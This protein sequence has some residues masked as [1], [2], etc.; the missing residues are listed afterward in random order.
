MTVQTAHLH[1][2]AVLGMEEVDGGGSV[3]EMLS[4][5]AHELRAPLSSLSAAAEMIQEGDAAEQQR[6]ACIIRRQA[7]RLNAII[8][9][10]LEAYGAASRQQRAE[11]GAV[12]LT[13]LLEEACEEQRLQF[14]GHRFELRTERDD[15][16]IVDRRM[17]SIVVSNLLS[18][19]AKYS[20]AGSV[21]HLSSHHYEDAVRIEVE[22]EGDGVPVAERQRIFEA[23]FRGR[24]QR[25]AGVGLGL[26]V[27]RT[28]CD[29]MRA[30]LIVESSEETG[31]ARFAVEVPLGGVHDYE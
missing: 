23:G 13:Q 24:Q 21:V 29:A 25:G 14:P 18:N 16:I 30:R 5:I 8:D 3:I 11:S 20:P 27:T 1:D 19:A 7:H 31:G 26:Y 28:L 22:D 10:L 15:Q 2:D 12:D 9:G 17:L 6:F 4:S